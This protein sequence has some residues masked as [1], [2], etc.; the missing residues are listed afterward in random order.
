MTNEELVLLKQTYDERHGLKP[1]S[2]Y[3]C[4]R[5]LHAIYASVMGIERMSQ[6]EKDG[7][8][9]YYRR[10]RQ[11]GV[12]A[13]YW[14]IDAIYITSRKGEGKKKFE[15]L[16]GILKKWMKYGYGF[17]PSDEE[18][19]IVDYFEEIVGEDLEDSHRY[20]MGEL[21]TGY[22]AV[23][24]TRM[25]G[26]L[27]HHS[28]SYAYLTLLR[29]LLES[30]Y[31]T[32]KPHMPELTI[33]NERTQLLTD[34]PVKYEQHEESSEQKS[35]RRSIED[36]RYISELVENVIKSSSGLEVRLGE[37]FDHL[38]KHYGIA[39]NSRNLAMQRV[40][41]INPSIIKTKHGYYGIETAE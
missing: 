31:A 29:D 24:V 1:E 16:I 11:K 21:I 26:S 15:Y 9:D 20:I 22:G 38:E 39:I 34:A 5:K 17:V 35:K 23:A 41:E 13:Y 27:D 32:K 14:L 36:Y 10:I 30:R 3:D 4:I 40:S 28:K 6:E 8:A 33:L 2:D 7:I 25:I 18:N 19:E 12:P 37:I